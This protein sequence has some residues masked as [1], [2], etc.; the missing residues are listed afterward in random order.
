MTGSIMENWLIKLNSKMLKN[1][2]DFS[3]IPTLIILT[4][5]YSTYF[6]NDLCSEIEE[7]Y[8]PVV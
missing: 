3:I 5:Q 6:K 7:K 2:T 4:I 8:K 1:K